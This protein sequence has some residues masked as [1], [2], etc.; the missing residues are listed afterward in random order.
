M[1]RAAD[2]GRGGQCAL[3]RLRSLVVSLIDIALRSICNNVRRTPPPG[4]G[5]NAEEEAERKK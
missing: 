1:C 3:W 4:V 2:R 5:E